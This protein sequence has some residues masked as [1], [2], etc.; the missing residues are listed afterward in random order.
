MP[1]CVRLCVHARLYVV[2]VPDYLHIHKYILSLSHFSAQEKIKDM[3]WGQNKLE[4]QIGDWEREKVRMQRYV[5]DSKQEVAEMQEQIEHQADEVR[6]STNAFALS[7]LGCSSCTRPCYAPESLPLCVTC[8][9]M[10]DPY[11]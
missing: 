11:A 7:R 4:R 5:Q 3:E 9:L 1:S 6:A 8:F 10:R 2:L